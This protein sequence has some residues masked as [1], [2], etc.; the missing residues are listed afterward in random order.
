MISVTI[1]EKLIKG[2]LKHFPAVK[3]PLP[4]AYGYILQENIYADR[5]LPPYPK[6]TM[7]GVAI[8]F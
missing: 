4:M 2:S 1:A 7:D 3:I 5:D 6:A 8:K